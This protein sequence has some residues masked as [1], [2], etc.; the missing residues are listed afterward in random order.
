MRVTETLAKCLCMLD[1]MTTM[2]HLQHIHA[3]LVKTALNNDTLILNKLVS[4]S[5]ISDQGDS[6]YASSIVK[7][8]DNPTVFVY[9]MLI[10]GFSR[11]PEPEKALFWYTSLTRRG[12]SPDRFTLPFLLKACSK[13]LDVRYG[14]QVH[15][16]IVKM[17][18]LIDAH[19]YAS[20]L[21]LYTSCGNL[22]CALKVFEAIPGRNV[23]AWNVMVS[24]FAR[25]GKF[26]EALGFFH[27]MR[28]AC[29]DFDEFSL[30]SVT[31]ACAN[32]G[33]ICFG[34]WVHGLVW[35][36]GFCEV[37]ALAN[38]LVDMYGK[39]GNLDDA[40]R[41][42][43]EMGV[44]NVVSWSTMIDV[45]GMHGCGKCALDLLNEMQRAGV[46]PDAMTFTSILCA[47]SHAGLLDEGKK[48][49]SRMIRDYGFA[50]LIQHYGCLVDLLG[51]AG[52]LYEAYTVVR[53]MPIKPDVAIWR[54]LVGACLFHD[55]LDVAEL[56]ANHLRRLNPDDR[57]DR[58]LLSNV[59]ARLGRWEDVERLRRGV[60]KSTGCSF[61]E[62]DGSV[63]EFV[64]RDTS[65]PQT[66]EIYLLINQIVGQM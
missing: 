15:C 48:W 14:Q 37:V 1:N 50:P 57:G 63:H 16:H 28:L 32:V 59:Y 66:R 47:C 35:R 56:A 34:K 52:R 8:V 45:F 10:R 3:H 12:L 20:L 27:Q 4:F 24:G 46:K 60:P 19:V 65:H 9:N 51:K 6:D 61:I 17:G 26:G 64:T 55:N 44:K 21:Y 41:M 29:E 11:S 54:S 43:N 23:V 58:V 40:Y 38:S 31:S 42:F 5:T 36:S 25:N 7:C 53:K 33:A 49:F 13:L 18:H 22:R 39:C 30:V 62:V 2:L